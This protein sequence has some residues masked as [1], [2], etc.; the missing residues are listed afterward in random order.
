MCFHMLGEFT[1]LGKL[2]A[3]LLAGEGSVTS[4]PQAQAGPDVIVL[5]GLVPHQPALCGEGLVAAWDVTVVLGQSVNTW[6]IIYI[7]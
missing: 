1:H 2:L 7:M 6:D 5:P 3:T 4:L